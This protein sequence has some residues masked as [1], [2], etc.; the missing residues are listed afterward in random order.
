VIASNIPIF[1]E[2]G[3]DAV[4]YVHPDSPA[5]FAAAVRE[6]EDPDLWK[7]RS[8]RSVERAAGFSWDE[9]ARRLLAAAEKALA[10]RADRP[11]TM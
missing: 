7:A 3:G 1:R 2:V 5:E 8:R 10:L 9:S 11:G 4:S 6:L